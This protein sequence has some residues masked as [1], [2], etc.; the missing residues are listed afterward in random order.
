MHFL[1]EEIYVRGGDRTEGIFRISAS[2]SDVAEAV[3]S[4]RRAVRFDYRLPPSEDPHLVAA[5]MK[6]WLRELPVPVF[7]DYDECIAV[8]RL[9]SGAPETREAYKRMVREFFL[10]GTVFFSVRI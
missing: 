2:H 10:F 3:Q 8:S 9:P 4:I 7:Q 1:V 6:Q 5:V